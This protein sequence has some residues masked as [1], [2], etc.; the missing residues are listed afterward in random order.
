MGVLIGVVIVAVA[1]TGFW[2]EAKKEVKTT[3]D[4]YITATVES[5]NEKRYGNP[6]LKE[7]E[8]CPKLIK[9]EQSRKLHKR[10]RL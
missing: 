3:V 10:V 7:R 4:D 2:T 5:K 6:I 8:D 1:I 9:P